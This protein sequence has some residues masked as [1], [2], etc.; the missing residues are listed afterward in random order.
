[1]AL[2]QTTQ[3][4]GVHLHAEYL[5]WLRMPGY[6]QQVAC[7][8]NTEVGADGEIRTPGQRFTKPLLYH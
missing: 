2:A 3:H 6:P 7:S 5:A 4:A 8:K 1:V